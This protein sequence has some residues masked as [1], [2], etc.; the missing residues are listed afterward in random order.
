MT[1]DAKASTGY[2]H[3]AYVIQLAESVGF[4]LAAKSK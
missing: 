2:V 4:K 1:Q 3:E